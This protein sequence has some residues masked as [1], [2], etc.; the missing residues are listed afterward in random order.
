MIKPSGELRFTVKG[1]SML[2]TLSEGDAV[3]VNP[4]RSPCLNDLICFRIPPLPDTFIHRVV[5]REGDRLLTCG[6]NRILPDRIISKSAL[7]GVVEGLENSP[8]RPLAPPPKP[9]VFRQVKNMLI[10]LK[11]FLYQKRQQTLS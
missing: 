3:R 9:F 10:K 4:D 2:P 6:D 1:T 8:D 7:L 11:L 5:A